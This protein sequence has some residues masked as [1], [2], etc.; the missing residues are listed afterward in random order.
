MAL[1]MWQ[2]QYYMPEQ[3]EKMSLN[4]R[5][6]GFFLIWS[7]CKMLGVKALCVGPF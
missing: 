4:P 3:G 1:G 5:S 6:L 7:L 2:Y